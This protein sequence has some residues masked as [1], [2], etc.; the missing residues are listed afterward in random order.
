[1]NLT[2]ST[3]HD[4]PIL[5]LTNHQVSSTVF[6]IDLYDCHESH[7]HYHRDRL[8]NL[9]ALSRNSVIK[10]SAEGFFAHDLPSHLLRGG[11]GWIG[12]SDRPTTKDRLPARAGLLRTEILRSRNPPAADLCSSNWRETTALPL[13]VGDEEPPCDGTWG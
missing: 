5:I 9:V 11:G 1:M 13:V 6:S 4:R 7:C 8:V 10:H 2:S 12:R 3:Q